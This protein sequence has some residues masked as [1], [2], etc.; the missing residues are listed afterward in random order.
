MSNSHQMMDVSLNYLH[1][2]MFNTGLE[3]VT[4]AIKGAICNA[5]GLIGG[6]SDILWVG[7]LIR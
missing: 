7:S 5:L 4:Q 6:L 1:I 3:P 2:K